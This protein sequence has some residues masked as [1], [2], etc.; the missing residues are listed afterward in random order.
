VAVSRRDCGEPVH[1]ELRCAHDY[2]VFEVEETKS[3]PARPDSSL[4][5][6]TVMAPACHQGRHIGAV[7]HCGEEQETAN[8]QQH[9]IGACLHARR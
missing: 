4:E 7:A 2:R 9:V 1:V 6:I 3:A 5:Q 8:Q